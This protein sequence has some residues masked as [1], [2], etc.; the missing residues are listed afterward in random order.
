ML[1]IEPGVSGLFVIKRIDTHPS[2][3][4]LAGKAM[5][6]LRASLTHAVKLHVHRPELAAQ[7]IRG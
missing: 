3:L 5:S 2:E 6:G 4:L 1:R 7:A